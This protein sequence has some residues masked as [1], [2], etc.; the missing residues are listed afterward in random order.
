LQIHDKAFRDCSWLREC[1]RLRDVN[2]S[3]SEVDDRCVPL[4]TEL[5]ALKHL[6]LAGTSITDEGLAVLKCT[7]LRNLTIG[8]ASL[9]TQG[10]QD[11]VEKN[12]IKYLT[13]TQMDLENADFSKIATFPK[14][15]LLRI[16]GCKNPSPALLTIPVD[17]PI[18]WI[19]ARD[20]TLD[21]KAFNHLAKLRSLEDVD[22][23]HTNATLI[24]VAT[25]ASNRT[26]R[27]VQC[28]GCDVPSDAKQRVSAAVGRP[29]NIGPVGITFE[30]V[31]SARE[32]PKGQ[33]RNR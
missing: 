12:R 13:L 30:V 10:I 11:C 21:R 33:N 29:I 4:L 3:E 31:P 25:I 18:T 17:S 26:V 1:K 5:P 24:D 32:A 14:L 22:L 28:D 9:T 23:G 16:S 20:C 7:N 27:T 8:S 19:E 15:V 2:F 6:D